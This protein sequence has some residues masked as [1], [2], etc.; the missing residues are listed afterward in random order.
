MA[1]VL[2]M[3]EVVLQPHAG[4]VL[5][6]TVEKRQNEKRMQWVRLEKGIKQKKNKGKNPSYQLKKKGN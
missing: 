1:C 6:R 5:G 4:I 3:M 2:P